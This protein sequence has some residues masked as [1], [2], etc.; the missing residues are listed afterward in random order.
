MGLEFPRKD[1][2]NEFKNKGWLG[3]KTEV[4]LK[5]DF[6][7]RDNEYNVGLLGN[8]F[9]KYY[10]VLYCSSLLLYWCILYPLNRAEI[11]PGWCLPVGLAL[12]VLVVAGAFLDFRK[13]SDQYK[14]LGYSLGYIETS[15]LFLEF[16]NKFARPWRLRIAKT[17][18]G[19]FRLIF[20]FRFLK[21]REWWIE[22]GLLVR[23]CRLFEENPK[24]FEKAVKEAKNKKEL[25]WL[26]GVS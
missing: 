10:W 5:T 7:F 1:V 17:P 20:R 11:L 12:M 26:L 23:A 4:E 18:G 8:F 25:K 15:E 9:S 6:I 13:G 24:N 21:H 22:Y 3:P 2:A 14:S 16:L 19:I